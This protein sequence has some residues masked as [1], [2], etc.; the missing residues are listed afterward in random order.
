[1]KSQSWPEA[2]YYFTWAVLERANKI[3]N[4]GDDR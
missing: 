1:M 3:A 4:P 2:P